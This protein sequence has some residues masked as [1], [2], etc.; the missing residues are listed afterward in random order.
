[1][2]RSGRPA[3]ASRKKTSARP[4]HRHPRRN[5]RSAERAS[6]PCNRG[7]PETFAIVHSIPATN[8]FS[9]SSGEAAYMPNEAS[10]LRPDY[11]SLQRRSRK[12]TLSRVRRALAEIHARVFHLPNLPDRLCLDCPFVILRGFC[13]GSTACFFGL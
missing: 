2:L 12:F 7:P 13:G 3:R 11:I 8:P 9:F 4:S 6:Q 5:R 1:M 10:Q